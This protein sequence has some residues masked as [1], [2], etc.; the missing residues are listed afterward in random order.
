MGRTLAECVDRLDAVMARTEEPVVALV[1]AGHDDAQLSGGAP[2]V[3][4]SAFAEAAT[5]LDERL[6]DADG[7]LVGAVVGLVP[8]LPD[9][10]VPFSGDQP[11]RGL[12]YDRALADV[13]TNHIRVVGD[14]GPTELD[15]W[16]RLTADGVT[17]TIAAT[18]GSRKPSGPGWPPCC[19]S[20][21]PPNPS[22]LV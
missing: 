15:D 9:H 7:L 12:E 21:Q 3:P 16:P 10:S 5:R 11:G 1:Q 4:L 20:T 8:L 13:V 14:S 19:D 2:R 22:R 18:T 17:R 6:T